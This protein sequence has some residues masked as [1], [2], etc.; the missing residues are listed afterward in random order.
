MKNTNEGFKFRQEIHVD[1]NGNM[2]QFVDIDRDDDKE[3][4]NGKKLD[5]RPIVQEIL[6]IGLKAFKQN[7]IAAIY[8]HFGNQIVTAEALGMQR[9][10]ISRVINERK[11][12]IKKE[13]EEQD[14]KKLIG[15][16]S[17]TGVVNGSPGNGG[18]GDSPQ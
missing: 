14:E 2:R 1:G 8:S 17:T 18:N 16:S 5:Y 12:R 13:K 3:P 10:Y 15:L 6:R 7:C 9:T 4:L 11:R